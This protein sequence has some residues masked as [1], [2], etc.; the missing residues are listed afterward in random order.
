MLPPD[1]Y[2]RLM[3]RMDVGII[4]LDHRFTIPNYPSRILSYMK[5]GKPVLACTDEVTD[6]REL[7][8]DKGRF[9]LWVSSGDRDGFVDAVI[10]LSGDEK[11]RREMGQR[12]FE[13]L[14]DNFE[15]GLSVRLLE[16]NMRI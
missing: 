16:E 1:E 13:Y 8:E 12:G 7:V 4:S 15:V 2:D 11:M 5:A 14:R 9:G 3:E 10:R 6:I